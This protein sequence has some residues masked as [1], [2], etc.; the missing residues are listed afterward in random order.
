MK[1]TILAAIATFALAYDPQADFPEGLNEDVRLRWAR[2]EPRREGKKGPKEGTDAITREELKDV[3]A[4]L[5]KG[6]KKKC[7]KGVR[8]FDAY[9]HQYAVSQKKV[10]RGVIPKYADLTNDAGEC[11]YDVEGDEALE[12]LACLGQDCMF[13]YCL[14]RRDQFL[15]D[16]IEN[17]GD[18]ELD[19]WGNVYDF[20]EMHGDL[21]SNGGDWENTTCDAYYELRDELEEDGTFDEAGY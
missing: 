13:D 9:C 20:G 3:L 10:D 1:F 16:C 18:R 5:D 6:A 21:A 2:G 4:D 19:N 14:H 7:A 17:D 8:K 15:A 12:Q 11:D